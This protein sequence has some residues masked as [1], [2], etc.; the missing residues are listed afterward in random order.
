MASRENIKQV[1]EAWCEN[2]P[3]F[4]ADRF[5]G[6]GIVICAGGTRYFVN[7]WVL[8]WTL[9]KVLDCTLPVQVWHLGRSEMSDG[10]RLML[11]EQGVEV[12]DAEKVLASYPAKVAGG[13]PLKPYAIAHS[14]FREVVY[15]DADTIPFTDPEVIFG[16]PEYSDKG[17][18]FWPDVLDVRETNPIWELLGLT[19]E[20]CVSFE[21]GILAVDKAR[22]WQGL[23]LATLLNENWEWLYDMLYGDKDTFLVAWQYLNLPFSLIKHRPGQGE[24]TFLQRAPDGSVILEHRTQAKLSLHGPNLPVSEPLVEVACQAALADLRRR[25]DGN[26]FHAPERSEAA[27]AKEGQL[28]GQ[29]VFQC[30]SR[31]AE[32]A[33][34]RLLPG[35]RALGECGRGEKS[36]AVVDDGGDLAIQFYIGNRASARLKQ[37]ADETWRGH[38]LFGAP[39][40]VALAPANGPGLHSIGQDTAPEFDAAYLVAQILDSSLIGAGF[41]ERRADELSAACRW[42]ASGNP[43]F[44]DALAAGIGE[45][46]GL[47][48]QRWSTHIEAVAR[49][50][51]DAETQRRSDAKREDI[52]LPG[53]DPE[54]Y[55]SRL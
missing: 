38:S 31:S 16:W 40:D 17:A 23:A 1:I 26:I 21:S 15:L 37:E 18:L 9:R 41:D 25:W 13:W 24:G 52:P 27:R 51:A 45:R 8:I 35:N 28:A 47:M 36:W 32:P 29:G 4:P 11:E 33:E 6:R 54:H 2:A 44:A 5:D 55:L 19:A 43:H 14:R 30:L 53:I 7:A 12:V 48:S 49:E 50:I 10:M 20:Q 22:A 42:L 46:R 3:P 34:V 39:Y